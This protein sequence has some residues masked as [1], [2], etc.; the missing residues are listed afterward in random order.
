MTK[1]EWLVILFP[2]SIY[3]FVFSYL[4]LFRHWSLNSSYLDLGLESQAL[5][6]TSQGRFFETSFGS[7]GELIS[8]LSYHFTPII[9][10][11][12]LIYRLLPFPETLLIFQ[13]LV[14][15]SGA[16]PLYWIAKRILKSQILSFFLGLSYLLYPSLE[17]S[18]LFDFHYV[19]LATTFLLFCFYFLNERRWLWFTLFL[20]LSVSTKENMAIVA[21]LFGI[22]L[23]FSLREKRR[24]VAVLLISLI[25]FIFSVFYMM[26]LLGGSLGA[27][28]RYST[29]TSDP[30]RA[31]FLL[32]D[33]DKIKYIFHL[34]VSV[35][36]LPLLSPGALFLGSSEI[37]LNLLSDYNPQWQVKF[38]Y[39]AAITP[40]VLVAAIFGTYRLID[41]LRNTTLLHSNVVINRGQRLNY[42]ISFYL[43]FIALVWNVLHSPS[44]LFY[45][46]D[47]SK[48]TETKETR[49]VREILKTIPSGVSVSA[50]NNL[51]S[52]LI[53]RRFLYLFPIK[54]LEADLVILDPGAVAGFPTGASI[55]SGEEYHH[56]QNLLEASSNHEKIIDEPHLLVYRKK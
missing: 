15:S 26:P 24:G 9:L 21:A 6:N 55:L 18:N 46:F 28:G 20:I 41:T 14:L 42:L 5:W 52:H 37:F 19:T 22:Y 36:F 34:L 1:K 7:S 48:Y 45:K 50:M 4:S 10:P 3:F 29:L 8:S 54:F 44:P 33:L 23:Y 31:L 13:T 32:F 40:F 35:G 49:K 53:N 16:I 2:V 39:T 27:V 30:I 25:Y 56:Y 38:H 11:L 12:A 43:L 47:R 51:G 17:Y